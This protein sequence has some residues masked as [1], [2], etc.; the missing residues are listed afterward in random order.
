[1]AVTVVSTPAKVINALVSPEEISYLVA[2]DAKVEFTFQRNDGIV[3]L[4]DEESSLPGAYIAVHMDEDTSIAVDNDIILIYDDVSKT[5]IQTMVLDA[6]GM[7]DTLTVELTADYL[8]PN[9]DFKYIINLTQRGN[10]YIGMYIYKGGEYSNIIKGMPDP[11]GLCTID[12]SGYLQSFLSENKTGTYTSI[13]EIE[14]N[15]CFEFKIY[16]REWWDSG[17]GT[18]TKIADSWYCLYASRTEEEGC[19]LSEYLATNTQEGKWFNLNDNVE[20]SIG[21]PMDIQFFW[22]ATYAGL[23]VVKKY[24]DAGNALLDTTYTTLSTTGKGKL[25]SI[26]ISETSLD[27]TVSYI[28]VSI[29]EV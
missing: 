7:T 4:V 23:Q 6:F 1:M 15:Q 19:N 27:S 17:A 5:M 26:K 28:M 29:E 24:Y 2:S 22:P 11:F 18:Q 8:P 14:S 20:Y 16:Y 3:T 25:N 12:I 10:A 9:T 21:V 13:N